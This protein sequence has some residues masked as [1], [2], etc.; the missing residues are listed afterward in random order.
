MLSL[1]NG[2]KEV[3]MELQQESPKLL[4]VDAKK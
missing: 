2:L 1:A 4:M 3:Q